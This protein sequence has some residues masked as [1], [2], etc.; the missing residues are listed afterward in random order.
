[1]NHSDNA[2]YT[3]VLA[4]L[5]NERF[6]PEEADKFLAVAKLEIKATLAELLAERQINTAICSALRA[7]QHVSADRLTELAT[8][9]SKIDKIQS[10][11]ASEQRRSEELELQLIAVKTAASDLEVALTK[12]KHVAVEGAS[13]LRASE[14]RARDLN[15]QLK[16]ALAELQRSQEASV[17]VERA[18]QGLELQVKAERE[19]SSDLHRAVIDAEALALASHAELAAEREHHYNTK[20]AL[21]AANVLITKLTDAVRTADNEI[22]RQSV[23]HAELT[24]ANAELITQLGAERES[25]LKSRE[26]LSNLIAQMTAMR[27]ELLN[28]RLSN[29]HTSNALSDERRVMNDLRDRIAVLESERTKGLI[30]QE[31]YENR[32]A[33]LSSDL[34]DIQS[35]LLAEQFDHDRCRLALAQASALALDRLAQLSVS[36]KLAR[37]APSLEHYSSVSESL[38]DNASDLA[39]PFVR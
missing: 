5:M 35:V 36:R 18:C 19:R 21:D 6:Q 15:E 4:K 38:N 17:S 26:N 1:M 39:Q 10:V 34:K 32:N 3:E 29:K 31:Q 2:G 7:A 27:T 14:A 22:S 30:T 37:T 23:A 28:E 24:T 9:V 13:L 25:H 12:E 33:K 20:I 8:N 11:L 16:Y